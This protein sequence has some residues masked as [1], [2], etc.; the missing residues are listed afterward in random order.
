MEMVHSPWR[1]HQSPWRFDRINS[2]NP[3][4]LWK[5]HTFLKTSSVD[6]CCNSRDNQEMFGGSST[7]HI[8]MCE[9]LVVFALDFSRN[10][11]EVFQ[12]VRAVP[13]QRRQ[14]QRHT[15]VGI[16]FPMINTV[17]TLWLGHSI[18]LVGQDYLIQWLVKI[19]W[20]SKMEWHFFQKVGDQKTNEDCWS[21]RLESLLIVVSKGNLCSKSFDHYHHRHRHRH[22][23]HRHH[24]HHRLL[25]VWHDG[26]ML[27][28]QDNWKY[29]FQ[30]HMTAIDPVSNLGW[31]SKPRLVVLYWW[32]Y[33]PA[34]YGDDNMVTIR[35]PINQPVI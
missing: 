17:R 22:R 35:I 12:M 13:L 27:T 15:L 31:A 14:W 2:Q 6:K 24:H 20:S 21:L 33:Y 30:I 16:T 9:F 19:I 10:F 29:P 7:K 4:K 1:T 28:C 3:G 23:H 11:E 34:I 5:T 18:I 26:F 32:L 25:T 8:G